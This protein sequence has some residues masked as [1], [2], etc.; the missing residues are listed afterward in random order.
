MQAICKWFEYDLYT[1]KY[2]SYIAHRVFNNSPTP[3]PSL[4]SRV[5]DITKL[6]DLHNHRK[7]SE[8]NWLPK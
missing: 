7:V 2:G 1:L 6:S 3:T 8:A 5:N 4:S